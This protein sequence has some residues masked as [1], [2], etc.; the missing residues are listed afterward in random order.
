MILVKG[1]VLHRLLPDPRPLA[2]ADLETPDLSEADARVM[3]A[4]RHLRLLTRMAEVGM[5]L[6][7]VVAQNAKTD[8]ATAIAGA[9]AFSKLSQA[10]RRTIALHDKLARDVKSDRDGL[11]AERTRRRAEAAEAY[12]EAKDEAIAGGVRDALGVA[13]PDGDGDARE[14]LVTDV[15]ESLDDPDELRGYLDR[16]V[17]ETVAKLCAAL[18]LDPDVVLFDGGAWKIRRTPSEFEAA[19]EAFRRKAAHAPPPEEARRPP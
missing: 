5:E 8:P 2:E 3:G 13:F 12:K 10:V 19:R 7:E 1:G 17:G 16:P 18:G 6:I 4:E 14:Q 15:Q 9:D 11:R